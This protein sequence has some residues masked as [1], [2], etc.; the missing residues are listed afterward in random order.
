MEIK[1]I[2]SNYLSDLKTTGKEFALPYRH[3]VHWNLSKLVI[4]IYS[5]AAG[6]VFSIPFLLAMGALGYY[7]LAFP[8]GDA[9][10]ALVSSRQTLSVSLIQ[11]ALLE[12]LGKVV[13]EILLFVCVLT[14]FSVFV[15]YGYYLLANAYRSYLEG[16]ELPIKANAYFDRKRIWKFTTALGWSS[17]YVLAPVLVGLLAFAVGIIFLS[18]PASADESRNLVLGSVTAAVAVA[19]FIAFLYFALRTGFSTF[20][21]LSDDSASE[22][23]R[24]YVRR[25]MAFTKG[26]VLRIVMLVLPFAIVAGFAESLIRDA[27]YAAAVSRM[28]SE[29]VR[30]KAESGSGFDDSAFLE[31]YLDRTLDIADQNDVVSIMSGHRGQKEGIDREFFEE[32]APYLDRTE[33]D[34]NAGGFESLFDLMSFLLLDG[35][36]S[37]AYLSVFL[38]LGGSLR[39]NAP[40]AAEETET[41]STAAEAPTEEKP[42]KAVKKP[43]A[44][45]KAATKKSD[46]E[47]KPKAPAKKKPAPK[48]KASE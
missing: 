12:N 32:I 16:V 45:P 4:F 11:F 25:S 48:K 9:T 26:K 15:T 1:K 23:G 6:L 18:D 28:Y 17:L 5:F 39:S 33:L 21:I 47:E 30:L 42:K 2:L 3:F 7:A 46:V 44:K 13:V 38:R 20:E 43:A 36:L 22:T 8:A 24:T 19:A 29:A 34:P 35:L 41:S 14:A 31:G 10:S 27:D 37:M 40:M